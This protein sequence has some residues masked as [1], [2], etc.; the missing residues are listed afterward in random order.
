M[1]KPAGDS[2]HTRD[3]LKVGAQ[4]FE[5]HRLEA[6]EK[7]GIGNVAR[8]P[9]SL[10]ILLEN[11]LRQEDGRFVHKEDIRALA[12]WKPRARSSAGLYGRAGDRGFGHHARG[13]QAH[14]WRPQT[15]QSAISGRVGNRSFR[16]GR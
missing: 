8:L 1:P 4:S 2:F 15:D 5:I 3:T 7:Q 14:G 13:R 9:F 10:K 16:S 12:E 6:L 11:L